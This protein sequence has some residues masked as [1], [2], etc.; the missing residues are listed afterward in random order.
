M[1]LPSDSPK[2]LET[3]VREI[4]RLKHLSLRTEEAYWGWIKR[5]VIFHHKRHPVE[6]GETEVRDFLSHLATHRHVAASTQNQALNALVFLYGAV[7]EKSLGSFADT[8]RAK[9]PV[10]LPV[11]LSKTEVRSLLAA[12]EGTWGLMA[13]LLLRDRYAVDGVRTVAGEGCG[14]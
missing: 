8:V 3:R 7:I 14:F 9:R 11:V 10:R 1:P 12:L 6:M 13:R 2:K 5:F 4:A